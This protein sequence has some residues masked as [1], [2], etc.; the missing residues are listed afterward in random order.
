M[1]HPLE[2]RAALLSGTVTTI[3][4]AEG[5]TPRNGRFGDR[6]IAAL[7][8]AVAPWL[9]F[10][11]R[12]LHPRMDQ[13]AIALPVI[14]IV[15]G[16]L[17]LYLTVTQAS[18]RWLLVFASLVLFFIASVVSPW[19]PQSGEVPVDPIRLA[20]VNT[21][22]YWFSD[23]DVGFLVNQEQPDLVVGVEL[24][25]SHDTELRSRFANAQADILPLERQRQNEEALQLDGDTY[26]K[27]GLPSIGVY[28]DLEMTLLPDPIEDRI[29]GGLPGFRLE[30]AVETGPIVV[31]AL[32]IPRPV[33]GDGPYEV[34]VSDH[35][36]MVDAIAAAVEAEELPTIVVGDLNSV[37]RG[38]SYRRLTSELTDAMRQ[39]EW[40]VPT[41][42]R[43][44]PFSLLFARIDHV[45]V[46]DGLCADNARSINTRYADHRPL[47]IDVGMCP[48]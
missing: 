22:L 21:G 9:W 28:S 36:E 24:A 20:T 2:A 8:V 6:R 40:A 39:G 1:A 19:R 25:E 7:A 44:L 30:V 15:L 3:A 37:D 42:D 47:V 17:A 48:S 23:N 43:P 33:G 10:L 34:S 11:V 41:A 32:H 38:Q 31:Y 27:N 16:V 12:S 45:L 35:V 26:R 18:I 5:E 13:I 14:S 46:S 29:D 4:P